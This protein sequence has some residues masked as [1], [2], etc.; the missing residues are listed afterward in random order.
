MSDKLK[1]VV[2]VVERDGNFLLPLKERKI[3]AGRRNGVGGKVEPGESFEAAAKREMQ[4]ETGAVV[5]QMKL[6]GSLQVI[7]P[8]FTAELEIFHVTRF[9]G[10]PLEQP[11]Q[12]MT[13]FRWYPKEALPFELMW[14]NDALWYPILIAGKQFHGEVELSE[15]GDVIRHTIQESDKLTAR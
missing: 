12:G 11:G 9:S 8:S 14:P 2:C 1:L 5:E 6:A 15:S 4:E 7:S 10:E 3:G 13:D